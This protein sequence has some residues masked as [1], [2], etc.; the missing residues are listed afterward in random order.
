MECVCVCKYKCIYARDHS[1]F[2]LNRMRKNDD[3]DNEDGDE[4]TNESSE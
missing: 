1:R 4:W 2:E 3:D